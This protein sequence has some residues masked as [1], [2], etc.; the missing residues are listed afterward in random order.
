MLIAATGATTGH[1]THCTIHLSG[2][3][4]S[5]CASV[6]ASPPS[7]CICA[8][9]H[10]RLIHEKKGLCEIKLRPRHIFRR[11]TSAIQLCIRVLEAD[12]LHDHDVMIASFKLLAVKKLL[13]SLD[14]SRLIFPFMTACGG[15]GAMLIF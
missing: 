13:F 6:S 15:E 11:I 1:M 3:P 9:D 4:N 14:V 2:S 7:H 8:A 12:S 10:Y 5:C